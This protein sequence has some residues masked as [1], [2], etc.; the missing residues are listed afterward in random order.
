MTIE[1]PDFILRLS[2]AELVILQSALRL[3]PKG[4]DSANTD[5]EIRRAIDEVLK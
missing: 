3:L 4:I 5:L 2:K 1:T